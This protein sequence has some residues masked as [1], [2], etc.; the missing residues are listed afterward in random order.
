M[1][2]STF[3][4]VPCCQIA[5]TQV[6]FSFLAIRDLSSVLNFKHKNDMKKNLK[7]L[8]LS[9]RTISNLGKPEMTKVFGGAQTYFC[10]TE[11][12]CTRGCGPT[13][14]GCGP[15]QKGHTCNNNCI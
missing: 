12:R 5:L 14:I 4:Y 11:R 6:A 3:G 13:V 7:K 9:K 2:K 1:S 8:N 15:T 10:D